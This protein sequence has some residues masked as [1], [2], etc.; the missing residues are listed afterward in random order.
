MPPRGGRPSAHACRATGQVPNQEWR[1]REA[2][3]VCQRM[4]GYH[5][6]KYQ[7]TGPESAGRFSSWACQLSRFEDPPDTAPARVASD[8]RSH[9]PLVWGQDI[10]SP[11]IGSLEHRSPLSRT[12]LT[13]P[14]QA[15]DESRSSHNN[16]TG[17][18]SAVGGH[19]PMFPPI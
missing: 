18:I 19:K 11:P 4:V 12:P 8:V 6:A 7:L 3:T 10:V 9:A 15:F 5:R 1:C 17:C 13:S 2:P 14:S 16:D